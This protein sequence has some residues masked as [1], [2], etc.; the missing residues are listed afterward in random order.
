MS[1][2]QHTVQYGCGGIF[3]HTNMHFLRREN[4]SEDADSIV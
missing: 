1:R 2:V 4:A 3:V